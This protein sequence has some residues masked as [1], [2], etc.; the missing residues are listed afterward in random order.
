VLWENF[1][2][3]R[4]VV[5]TVTFVATSIVGTSACLPLGSTMVA[6]LFLPSQR[7]KK[8]CNNNKIVQ[9]FNFPLSLYSPLS[10]YQ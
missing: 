6:Q 10:I 4:A 8:C 9:G 1:P 2:H 3:V 5:A 7:K